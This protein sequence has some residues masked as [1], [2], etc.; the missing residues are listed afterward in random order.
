MKMFQYSFKHRSKRKRGDQS[1]NVR[2][3]WKVSWG[4]YMKECFPEAVTRERMF[5]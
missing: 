2:V 5:C 1:G 4:K 3:L